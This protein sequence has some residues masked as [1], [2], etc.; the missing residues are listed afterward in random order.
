MN[1]SP[2]TPASV[3]FWATVSARAEA[4]LAAGAMHDFQC[5]LQFI[6]DAGVEFV[7][8][9][10][11]TFPRGETAAGRGRDAPKLAANPFLDPEP[12]LVV[13]PVGEGHLAVL[14]KFSVLREHLLLVTRHFMDQRTLLGERD[15]AALAQCMKEAE[16]LAFYNGGAEAGASQAHK[17]VQIVTLPLS[18]RRSVPMS[19]LL[20][21]EPVAL[22]FRHAFTRLADGDTARPGA[23]LAAYRRLLEG[24]GVKALRR[25][26]LEWQ[27]RPYSLVVTHEWM[28]VVPRSRDRFEAISIN[29]LAFAGSFFVR[30]A[31]QL[32]AIARAGPMRVLSSV[33]L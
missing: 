33:A 27:S 18:P 12:H 1:D 20:E 14:N 16:V 7:A 9:R 4:A 19:A 15:F 29:T 24:A 6:E 21:R 23:L 2:R 17:H 28:L 25:D 8:R 22:P 32:D 11:T 3:R 10:A 26:G 5:E 13:G 30:D 31:A